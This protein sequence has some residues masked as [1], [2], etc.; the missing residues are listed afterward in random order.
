MAGQALA[1]ARSAGPDAER[2]ALVALALARVLRGRGIEDLLERSA[3]LPP[4]TASLYDSSVDSPAGARLMFR[5]QLAGAR[6]VFGG[7]LAEAEQ[8]GEARSGAL[9]T[10]QLCKVE[11]RAGDTFAAARALGELDQWAALD[12]ITGSRVWVQA[13]VAA[14]RGDAGRATALA[15]AV[16]QARGPDADEWDRLEARRAAGLA[17]LLD[18]DPQ[19]AVTSLAAVWQHT[20]REGVEDPGAFP[21]AGDLAEAL[22]ETGRPAE[23]A[24]VTGRLAGLAAAQQHPWGLA[25]ADRSAAVVGL[26]GGY[27][28]AAAAQLAGAA[29]AYRALGLGFDAARALLILGRAQRRATKRA[30]ARDSLEQARAGFEALGCPGWA[31]AAAAE[32]DRVSGRRAAPGGGLTPG[33]RRSRSW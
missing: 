18:R 22:A 13:A 7:L 6:E 25:T 29:A 17:A 33:E 19:Q 30:A 11:L 4:G 16:L 5:G 8:R 23:A 20:Q 28:E 1:A 14:V 9:F 2:K 10:W 3:A 21:V 12:W 26:A 27:D 31:Q 24:Q 32:A 15:A